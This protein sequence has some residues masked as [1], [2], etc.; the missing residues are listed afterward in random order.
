MN[1]T[2]T[3]Y[4]AR[5][6][7][8][9]MNT[10]DKVQGWCD[11]PLTKEGIEVARFLGAGLRDIHFESVYSSDLR[12]TSQTAKILLKEQGQSDLNITEMEEFREACFGSFESSSNMQMWRESALY[13][14]YANPEDMYHDVFNKKISSKEI[15]NAIAELDTFDMAETFEQL[16]AR[17]QKGLADVAKTE[18]QKKRDVNVL[19][20]AHG[21]CIVGMLLNLGGREILNS[22]LENASVCKVTYSDGKFTVESM[23]D[24][25][26]VRK[27]REIIKE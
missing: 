16:E 18:S 19:I 2:I 21:M 17:T 4:I 25:S 22:H 7:K 12:R 14:H 20:V 5:H 27:G 15:L 26:F 9:L 3:F 24:M 23:G 1:N 13:L 11:S 8:T 10:L 6:G